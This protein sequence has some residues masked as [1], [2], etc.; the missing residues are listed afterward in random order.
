MSKLIILVIII[1]SIFIYKNY[2]GKQEIKEDKESFDGVGKGFS[3][4]YKP[5]KCLKSN[6]CFPGMYTG[7]DFNVKK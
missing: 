7:N 3:V 5:E 2:F 6:N 4:Y 1:I